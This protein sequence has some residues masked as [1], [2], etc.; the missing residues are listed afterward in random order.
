M[1]FPISVLFGA[2]T[3]ERWAALLREHLGPATDADLTDLLRG[4]DTWTVG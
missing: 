3:I 2:P 4:R 1:E